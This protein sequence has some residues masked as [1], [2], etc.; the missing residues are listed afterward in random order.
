MIII[1]SLD[2][3]FETSGWIRSKTILQYWLI[4]GQNKILTLFSNNQIELKLNYGQ[5]HDD[6]LNLVMKTCGQTAPLRGQTCTASREGWRFPAAVNQMVWRE[7]EAASAVEVNL[8]RLKE[9]VG[10]WRRV[11]HTARQIQSH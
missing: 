1:S 2:F 7:V 10:G 11:T 4:S 5:I 6:T 8:Q 3:S 9:E